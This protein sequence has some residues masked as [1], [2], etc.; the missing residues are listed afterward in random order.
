MIKTRM[1]DPVAWLRIDELRK[2]G[3]PYSDSPI[4]QRTDSMLLHAKG[5]EGA[6]KRYGFDAPVITTEQAEA[7]KDACVEEALEEAAE[8]CDAAASFNAEMLVK[9]PYPSDFYTAY[10]AALNEAEGMASSIRALIPKE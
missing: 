10:S 1:P 8:L 5:T 7:Y 2:L 9:Q 3:E 6:A 4:N